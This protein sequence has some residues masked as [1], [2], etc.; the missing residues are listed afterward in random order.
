MGAG[1]TVRSITQASRQQIYS[2]IKKIF[3]VRSR[4]APATTAPANRAGNRSAA[5]VGVSVNGSHIDETTLTGAFKRAAGIY[6]L[7][8]DAESGLN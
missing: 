2:S 6:S 1:E 8:C 7:P 4:A 3:I 5:N